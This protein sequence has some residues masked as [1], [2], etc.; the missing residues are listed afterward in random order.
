MA[1]SWQEWYAEEYKS[2]LI[3][4]GCV[5]VLVEHLG[6][7]QEEAAERRRMRNERTSTVCIPS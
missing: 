7:E 2:M 5:V 3:V 4:A 1:S 6:R